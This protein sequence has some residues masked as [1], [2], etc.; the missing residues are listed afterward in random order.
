MAKHFRPLPILDIRNETDD[1]VSVSFHVPDE[2][3]EEFKFKAGQN[4]TL[5]TTIRGEEIR[6]SYSI[7]SS[8]FEKE[9]RVA[10]KKVEEGLFSSHA[11]THFKSA[12]RLDV[13]TPTGNFV[14]PI[15]AANKKHYVAFAAGSGITPVISLLKT[16]LKE[17]P[18][19]RFTL[20]YGNR[21][22]GSVIFRE[23]LL[24]LKNEFPEQFQLMMVF[25][26]EK[27][28]AP[29]FEGRIDA[30]K[31]EMI[32]KQILPLSEDQEYLL[33]GPAPMIFSVRSWLLEQKIKE[34]KIHFELFSD[35]GELG[36]AKEKTNSVIAESSEIKSLVTIRLDGVSSDYQIPVQGPTILEAAIQAGAD[37]PYACR[38]GVCASCRAKLVEGKVSMDQNYSL[39][40]E[41]IEQGFILTCQ[42]HPASEKL[43]VDFDIR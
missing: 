27:M 23:E 13:L 12:Q 34:K 5:R 7:C 16:I 40:D 20:I 41:E 9:L 24:A 31:C 42:S 19:S 8:P 10:I 38:A 39:A 32:F 4:I 17:E 37:L 18:F 2:W 1:C 30:S 6:R 28:D 15:D 43:M 21:N 22:R 26:R 14:L 33:C 35:P 11:H 25:S 29:V 36:K 3:K